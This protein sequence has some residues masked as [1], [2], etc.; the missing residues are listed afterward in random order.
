M[1]SGPG[2]FVRLGTSVSRPV[3]AAGEVSDNPEI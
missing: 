3:K 2:T 1:S